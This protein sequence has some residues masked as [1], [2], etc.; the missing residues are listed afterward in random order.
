MKEA[1]RQWLRS[2][3]G[4]VQ[5]TAEEIVFT[6][7][8]GERRLLLL[9]QRVVFKAR[10]RVDEGKRELH[11]HEELWEKGGGLPPESGGGWQK[12]VY[13]AGK[14]REGKISAR[15]SLLASRFRFD[16]D[17]TQFHRELENLAQEFGYTVRYEFVP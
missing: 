14:N 7:V 2:K 10:F 15:F 3:G 8:L 13:Q 4:E 5:E 6:Q 1:L 9:R 12:E 11:V 17:Y 16:F